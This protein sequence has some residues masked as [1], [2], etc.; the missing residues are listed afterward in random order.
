MMRTGLSTPA[1]AAI[2]A[3]ALTSQTAAQSWQT[4][5]SGWRPKRIVA[6]QDGI[7]AASEG[8]LIFV[9]P[10][11][12]ELEVRNRDQDLFANSL[13]VVAVEPG[14][15]CLWVGYANGGLDRIDPATGRVVQRI[16]DF[17]YENDIFA[18]NDVAF[19]DGFALV[20]TSIGISRLEPTDDPDTWVIKET[21]REFGSWE[22]PVEVLRVLPGERR[23]FV[24]TESG[25]AV[26][27]VEADLISAAS[28]TTYEFGDELPD[29]ESGTY[30]TMIADV[31]DE[32]YAGFYFVG[33]YKYTESGFDL[34]GD[35]S[36][37]LG[38]TVTDEGRLYLAA[39]GGLYTLNSSGSAWISVDEGFNQKVFDVVNDNGIFW[40]ALDTD[41][42]HVGGIARYD[43]E[44]FTVIN[45]N[46]TGADQVSAVE[47]A[48]DGAVWVNAHG[49]IVSGMFRFKDGYWS[50]FTRLN[51]PFFFFYYSLQAIG[52][53]QYGG[54]WIGSRG[55]GVLYIEPD[56]ERFR[57]YHFDSTDET[58]GR[59]AGIS[60]GSA[61]TLVRGF[62]SDPGGGFW[63]SNPEG[64]GN[65]PLIYVPQEWF[66]SDSAARV[67]IPWIEF[68]SS[69]RLTTNFISLIEIDPSGRLWLG[70]LS[71]SA[72]YPLVML[73]H[74]GTI[75]KP[76]D[77]EYEYFG[78][79]R[80]ASFGHLS[81]MKMGD[82]GV[83]WLGTPE[84]LFY[85]DTNL[86]PESFEIVRK[87]GAIGDQISAVAV[88]PLGQ[89]WVGTDFGVSVLSS[90]GFFWQRHYTSE[91]EEGAYPSPLVSNQITAMA[92]DSKTGNVYIGTNV[93]L[94]ILTTPYRDFS[95]E[96]GS[97]SVS[98][99]PF[100]TGS[101]RAINLTFSSTSLVAGAAVK[102]F[103]PS[104]R[105][106][107]RL[108]FAE[109]SSLGWNG[110]DDGGD[111]VPSGVYL[112]VVTDPEG[113]SKVGKA[114]LVRE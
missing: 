18:V 56:G 24:G 74:R 70:P 54:S 89:V 86:E 98:P 3:I 13:N 80:G 47:I 87:R 55:H 114:A 40:L 105:L 101:A 77:D 11:T 90:D 1:L 29:R 35:A 14:G 37:P 92:F 99:Q 63:M 21:Y 65:S 41:T 9:D 102:I 72:T 34:V 112:I 62:A 73:D 6:A 48:P 108:S 64:A 51:V 107:R 106:V 4:V 66:E 32:I 26:A 52:F 111:W 36:N 113:R 85:L 104:G 81:D 28:W 49:T 15:L 44:S 42:G 38:L 58:G 27:S 93:G 2:V 69:E 16:T 79:D 109:A 12:L 68:G 46:T 88:D 8:G 22:R 20:A 60:E 76:L 31:D 82:D 7:W 33:L 95:D 110:R 39:Q 19:G 43:G 59:L 103:T 17:Y 84:G 100:I 75:D 83:L 45:P 97:I 57:L 25:V 61:F 23:V 10:A 71:P 5:T 78:F 50:G 53:D 96:L 30:V 91:D 94:S 67:D